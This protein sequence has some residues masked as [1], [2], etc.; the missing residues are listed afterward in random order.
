[1]STTRLP[2]APLATALLA[3]LPA[4][5]IPF[6]HFGWLAA[7]YWILLIGFAGVAAIWFAFFVPAVHGAL[8]AFGRPRRWHFLVAMLLT[9]TGAGVA[10][11]IVA[12]LVVPEVTDFWRG[13]TVMGLWGAW[14]GGLSGGMV[15]RD[16]SVS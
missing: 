13:P 7:F 15:L 8:R 3:P 10:L 4:L 9:G 2:S 6:D 12:S 16:S 14:F 5:F 1:M 11:G